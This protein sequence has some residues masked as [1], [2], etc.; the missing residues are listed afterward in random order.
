MTICNNDYKYIWN[1]LKYEG[2][3]SDRKEDRGGK[4]FRGVTWK[5]YTSYMKASAKIPSHEHHEELT[6]EEVL[7]IYLQV[8]VHP[9]RISSYDS[10]WVKEAIFSASI[11]HG[12][13]NASKMVQRAAKAKLKIDGIIGPKTLKEV[14][15]IYSNT[16]VNRLI[17]QRIIFTDKIV[18]REVR[19]EK[20]PKE[21]SQVENLVGWHRRYLRYI[22]PQ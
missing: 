6:D 13:R 19:E 4:T 22:L 18:R 17:M 14:N 2:R 16:F 10:S 7:D 21:E 1:V 15:K 5:T 3:F 9:L 12:G 11:N 8:F 20:T